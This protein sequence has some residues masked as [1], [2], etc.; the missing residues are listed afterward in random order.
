MEPT[1]TAWPSACSFHAFLASLVLP[2]ESKG[3]FHSHYFSIYCNLRRH[4]FWR[5][6]LF[7]SFGNW[8]PVAVSSGLWYPASSLRVPLLGLIS[9][10]WNCLSRC[11][12]A[13]SSFLF[14]FLILYSFCSAS[15]SFSWHWRICIDLLYTQ[16][17]SLGLLKSL[18]I[19]VS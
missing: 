15:S 11:S 2:F 12:V 8:Q 10:S 4:P 9:R 5:F 6:E 3:T 1:H 17:S 18:N 7:F 14:P 16:F 19:L 13:T